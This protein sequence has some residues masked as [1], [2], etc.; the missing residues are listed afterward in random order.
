[1]QAPWSMTMIDRSN[2][3]IEIEAVLILQVDE[4][5]YTVMTDAVVDEDEE[6]LVQFSPQAVS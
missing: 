6:S 3:K 5:L 2:D 4:W 1:M